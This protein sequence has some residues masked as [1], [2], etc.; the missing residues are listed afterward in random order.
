MIYEERNEHVEN[1]CLP[2]CFSS[3]EYLK[4]RLKASKKAQKLE[5]MNNSMAFLGVN[6]EKGEQ[7]ESVV[8]SNPPFYEQEYN[9][10]GVV[11]EECYNSCYEECS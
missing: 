3:F 11:Q 8:H 4:Q 6:N 10:S 1:N 2:M 7:V 5:D 9:K